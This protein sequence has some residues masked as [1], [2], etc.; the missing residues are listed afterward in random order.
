MASAVYKSGQG[1]WTRLGSAVGAGVLVA[2]GAMWL[3]NQ[4][5]A[6]S[7]PTNDAGAPL[8][9]RIYLQGGVAALVMLIGAL[10]V[11][12]FVYAS[13]KT[14]EFLIATEGEM[15][16]VNW[17][18]R[19]EVFGST[20]VVILISM[21]IATILLIADIGFSTIF[22]QA[23][24]LKSDEAEVNQVDGATSGAG[25]GNGTGTLP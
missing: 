19:K 6:V 8:F 17:S 15:K 10:L 13:P 23:G 22:K 14:G 18:T 16:K 20:W 3:W 24:V 4:L 11:F 1:Y 12:R 5:S 25:T 21:V 2:S 9:E 7:L